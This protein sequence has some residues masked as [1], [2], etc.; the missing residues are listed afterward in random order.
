MGLSR[1][2]WVQLAY[3]I[4]AMV[5]FAALVASIVD[6]PGPRSNIAVIEKKA[7]G[8][9]SSSDAQ[10]AFLKSNAELRCAIDRSKQASIE[11]L[12][13]IIVDHSKDLEG[14]STSSLPPTS[15][16]PAPDPA[17]ANGTSTPGFEVS[18]RPATQ[19]FT[20][21][22]TR[23]PDRYFDPTYRP[24]V[25][26]HYVR[27]YIRRDGT[28]VEGH[29]RTNPDDSFWNNYSSHGNVNPFTGRVGPPNRQ[30][31]V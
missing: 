19:P 24:P 31:A 15:F 25:G 20:S 16:P 10:A 13:E 26:A 12:G 30:T 17:G 18:D 5:V 28:Y 2:E 7:L 4:V 21:P 1:K 23:N 22:S 9:R 27:P 8:S 3:G 11:L 14:S 29:W 6:E